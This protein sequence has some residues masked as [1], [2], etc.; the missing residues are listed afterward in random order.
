MISS[1]NLLK[2]SNDIKTRN[3]LWQVGAAPLP[4]M[5]DI[6]IKEGWINICWEEMKEFKGYP[7]RN[8]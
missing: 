8:K 7:D 5:G 1:V 6:E 4:E 2:I 3:Q